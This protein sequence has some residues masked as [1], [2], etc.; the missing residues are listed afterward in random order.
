MAAKIKAI[1]LAFTV[2]ADES[3]QLFGGIGQREIAAALLE[4]GF[5]ID[6]QQIVLE[7]HIKK[8]GEHQVEVKIL[9]DIHEKINV[10][11]EAEA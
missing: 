4:K 7:T 9:G 5:E 3:G 1:T 6:K 11:V 2:A 8:I 10:K